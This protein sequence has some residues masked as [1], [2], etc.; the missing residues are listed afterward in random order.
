[1]NQT[2]QPK[3]VPVGGQY[4]E[5]QHDE[6]G[7]T[8]TDAPAQTTVTIYS[9]G[10]G[11]A[12]TANAL[13]EEF[14]V[15]VEDVPRVAAEHGWEA[16]EEPLIEV[17]TDSIEL[18][19]VTKSYQ[20]NGDVDIQEVGVA[21]SGDDETA[22]VYVRATGNLMWRG[23]EF[24]EAELDRG[25]P[26]VEKAYRDWFGADIF[27]HDGWGYFDVEMYRE[28]P[29]AELTE[30]IAAERAW[31][32]TAKWH[33]ETD[34]GTFG[35][36]YFGAELRRRLDN[37]KTLENRFSRNSYEPEDYDAETFSDGN[38]IAL[39]TSLASPGTVDDST[40]ADLDAFLQ[41]GVVHDRDGLS[42]KLSALQGEHNRKLARAL[43]TWLYQD[44]D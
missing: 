33:N 23:D 27:V 13:A 28:V 43:T 35:S 7:A 12:K 34:P 14:G 1:M 36:P 41:D 22:H 29:R 39:A 30:S 2:R 19:E 4:A 3:G 6:A 17:G 24:T 10:Y 11:D 9:D 31:D 15:P 38:A 26:V 8:L 18:Y 16:K 37:S 44:E 25:Y 40:R 21:D 20:N 42:K 5:N 32:I